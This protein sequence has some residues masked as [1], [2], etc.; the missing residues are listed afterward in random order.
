MCIRDSSIGIAVDENYTADADD[1]FRRADSA[2]YTAKKSRTTG[3]AVHGQSD[4]RHISA[5][6]SHVQHD[7]EFEQ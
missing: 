5:L 6:G 1:L 7:L 3:Y 2:M 4:P